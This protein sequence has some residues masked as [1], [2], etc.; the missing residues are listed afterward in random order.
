MSLRILG[1]ITTEKKYKQTGGGMGEIGGQEVQR[2][3]SDSRR[4]DNRIVYIPGK[5]KLDEVKAG[6]Y[7]GHLY[8][9]KVPTNFKGILD[10]ICK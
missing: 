6:F 2:G 9:R 5:F 4:E 10:T 3:S 7:G 1:V 8:K